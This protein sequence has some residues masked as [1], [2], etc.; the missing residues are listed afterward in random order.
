MEKIPQ[1]SRHAKRVSN[2]HDDD[3][4]KVKKLFGRWSTSME[5]YKLELS[6]K[7]DKCRELI[8]KA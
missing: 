3:V 2:V 5:Y 1:T 7:K 6:D 8:D 4:P